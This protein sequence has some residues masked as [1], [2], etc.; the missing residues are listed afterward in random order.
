MIKTFTVTAAIIALVLVKSYLISVSVKDFKPI[1]GAWTGTITYK[2]YTSGKPFTMPANVVVEKDKSNEH[3][4]ILRFAYPEEPKANGNDTLVFSRD[5]RQLNGEMV[6]SKEKNAEGLLQVV[7]EKN[8]VDG[9]DNRTAIL[10]H[11]YTIGKRS[12]IIRKEVRFDGEQQFIMRNEFKMS[13]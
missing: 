6:I 5:G 7:T 9:N 12:F 1:T 13:R 10:R 8:G 2:D 11:I 3:H 4:L